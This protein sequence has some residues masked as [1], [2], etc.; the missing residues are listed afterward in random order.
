M[1]TD[2][3]VLNEDGK[4]KKGNNIIREG[5]A[6]LF[7]M[8]ILTKLFVFDLIYGLWLSFFQNTLVSKL[9][10]TVLAS[11]RYTNDCIIFREKALKLSAFVLFYPFI[12]IL[13]RIPLSIAKKRVRFW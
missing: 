8:Y 9:Q 6:I 2:T 10:V 1:E 7:W 12:L 13:W 3:V 11:F 4:Q 5:I